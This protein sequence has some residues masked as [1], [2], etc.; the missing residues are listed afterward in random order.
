LEYNGKLKLNQKKPTVY[1][2]KS[3]GKRCRNFKESN[4]KILHVE[5]NIK[6]QYRIAEPL[7]TAFYLAWASTSFQVPSKHCHFHKEKHVLQLY[8]AKNFNTTLL[9]NTRTNY[10]FLPILFCT[11]TFKIFVSYSTYCTAM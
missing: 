3:S 1:L 4:K 5:I 10:A 2:R 8:Y 6:R 7:E 11:R 9:K